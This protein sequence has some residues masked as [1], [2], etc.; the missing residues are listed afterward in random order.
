[1]QNSRQ[2]PDAVQGPSLPPG[3]NTANPDAS[4]SSSG[5]LGPVQGPSRPAPQPAV[6]ED[7]IRMKPTHLRVHRPG[8]PKVGGG[9][10]G[11]GARSA[12][13]GGA[14]RSS[15]ASGVGGSSS[16]GLSVPR[17]AGGAF[18]TPRGARSA[19]GGAGRWVFR[20]IL[21]ACSVE[22]GRVSPDEE[23][24]V[25]CFCTKVLSGS[26]LWVLCVAGASL[27]VGVSSVWRRASTCPLPVSLCALVL[28]FLR[29]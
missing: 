29:E 19:G 7:L 5:T 6:S 26:L 27:E 13:G 8:G 24:S 14:A 11:V 22:R 3:G 12:L 21:E 17:P 1:M 15:S 10:G 2:G 20:E 25:A 9:A 4:S 16:L 23:S 28:G 18:L